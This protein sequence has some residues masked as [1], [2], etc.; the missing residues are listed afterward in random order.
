MKRNRGEEEK[1]NNITRVNSCFSIMTIQKSRRQSESGCSPRFPLTL[2]SPNSPSTQLN[3][4]FRRLSIQDIKG[5]NKSKSD[6]VLPKINFDKIVDLKKPPNP[7]E[8]SPIQTESPIFPSMFDRFD[9]LKLP[10]INQGSV[11]ECNCISNE[12]LLDLLNGKFKEIKNYQIIDCRFPF[13]Y[14]GGHIQGS[15]NL[16]TQ[17]QLKEFLSKPKDQILIFHCEFSKERGPRMY[18]NLRKMD[19]ELNTENYPNL[20]YP[21]I[22]LLEGGYK[23]F[24]EN[25]EKDF[26]TPK[27][28]ISM[29]NE[30]YTNEKNDYWKIYKQSWKEKKRI[31]VIEIQLENKI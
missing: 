9:T 22:Y 2:E 16:Y 7:F 10:K 6:T 23:S 3:H 30:K 28:Y 20:F 31:S 4:N 25:T 21:E 13:E 29:L 15:I 5:R 27:S 11:A 12:T 19:R 14:E 1:E 24:Y 17:D 26:C 18:R 8:D